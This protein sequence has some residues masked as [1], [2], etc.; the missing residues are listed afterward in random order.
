MFLDRLVGRLATDALADCGHQ[1][2][3]RGEERQIALQLRIHYSRER[4]EVTEHGEEGL[5]QTIERITGIG[6]R[7]PAH[8]RARHITLVP[9]IARK[10]ADHR[11]I[12]AQD[13]R[14]PVH[15]LTRAGVHLVGH[16][17]GADLT[18][19]EPLGHQLVTG[20]Q[21]DRRGDIRRCRRDLGQGGQDI[22]VERTRIDLTGRGE[23]GRTSQVIGDPLFE[24]GQLGLVAAQQIQ[25]VLARADRALDA[26]QRI[27][28]DEFV[29]ALI[30]DEQLVSG[31]REAL[32]QGRDLRRDIVRAPGHGQLG[33][34]PRQPR[35][36]NQRRHHAVAHQAQRRQDLELL[37]VLGQVARGHALVDMLEPGEVVELLDAGLHVML[38]DPLAVGDRA[39]VDA[40]DH[41]L[42]GGD[43][44]IRVIPA[45][46]DTEV[47]LRREDRDPQSPLGGDLLLRRPDA[48]HLLGGIAGG[49]DV[50]DHWKRP[51]SG[52]SYLISP[53]IARS[54]MSW[55]Q[56]A[57]SRWKAF[58]AAY[59]MLRAKPR[60]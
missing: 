38:G 44:R 54:A 12:A 41:A 3:G 42:I 34:L 7:D 30:G 15:T 55:R 56:N 45:E 26:A 60:V 33:V 25:H 32:A 37:D 58:S 49:E 52:T 48:T 57:F 8:H 16:R 1:H 2:L 39:Q 13:H 53:L 36:R 40:I 51:P 11:P 4:T 43:H 22:P 18:R 24:L 31:G 10:F 19:L 14:E 17:R 23:H 21:P 29:H 59:T 47:T 6:E 5:E 9:L 27:A 50:G 35:Q 20:H 46:V 28:L